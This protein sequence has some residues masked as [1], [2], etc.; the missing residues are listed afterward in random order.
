MAQFYTW[1]LEE[2][3]SHEAM[4]RVAV[5]I[6]LY[7]GKKWPMPAYVQNELENTLSVIESTLERET[8]PTDSDLLA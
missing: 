8:V 6:A 7:L 5:A 4:R 1:P 3:L 2:S